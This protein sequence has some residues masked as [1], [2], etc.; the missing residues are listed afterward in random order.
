MTEP[1]KP[2][3][4][5][6]VSVEAT[7]GLEEIAAIKVAEVE[8]GLIVTQEQALADVRAIETEIAK[9]DK[10]VPDQVVADT[11]ENYPEIVAIE[12]ALK[13]NFPKSF[14]LSICLDRDRNSVSIQIQASG[15]ISLKGE[16]SK[17][18]LGEIKELKGQV[19]KLEEKLVE[20]KKKLQ[21][22][23]CLERSA[24]AAVARVR[25]EKTAEG[26]KILSQI[27]KVTLPGLP[28]PKKG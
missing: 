3:Q 5:E 24:K 7:V 17:A 25:L 21:Q 12:E 19:D 1:I 15:S 18:L 9:L 16:K 23:P 6:L 22:L 26:K 10:K 14:S 13:D 4:Q 27:D 2:Q 11:K 20:T 28:A 8:R